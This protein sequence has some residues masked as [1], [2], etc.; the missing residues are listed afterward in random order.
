MMNQQLVP[1]P[2]VCP[3]DGCGIKLCLK[4]ILEIA[5][6]SDMEKIGQSAVAALLLRCKDKFRPCFKTGCEQSVYVL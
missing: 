5:S 6:I 3:A 2:I 1:Y 4:D